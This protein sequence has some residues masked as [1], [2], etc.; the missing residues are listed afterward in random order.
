MNKIA[1]RTTGLAIK[2]ISSLSKARIYIHGKEN[3]C[4]GSLIFVA[5]HFTR[6]ETLILPYYIFRL[7]GIPAWSLA[8]FTLFRGAFGE[9]LEAIGAISTKAP[10][11]DRLMV[12]TLLTGEGSWIIYPEGRMVK[13]KKIFEKGKYMISYAGGKHPPHT[14]A[15]T[16]ALR[17]EFYRQRLNILSKKKIVET[18]RLLRLFQIDSIDAISNQNIYIIPVNVTYYPLRAKENIL[19]EMIHHLKVD[20]SDRMLE[21][22]MT[23]GSMLFS[24]VDVDI[25][26]GK[27]IGIEAYMSART[28]QRDILSKRE[29]GFDDPIPS[30]K[31]MRRISLAIMHRYMSSIYSMTTVNHDHLQASL[32]RMSPFRKLHTQDLRQ[33]L[34]YVSKQG[35]KSMRIYLHRDLDRNQLPLLTDNQ[36]N[37]FND[38]LSFAV[39]KKVIRVKGTRIEK[40]RSKFS[41]A[42]D[43]QRIRIDNPIEVMANEIE[44]LSALQRYLRRI[45]W[46]PGFW[47]RKKLAAQLIQETLAE[48]EQDYKTFFIEG[49]SKGRDI[50]RPLLYN[51]GRKDIGVVLIHGYLSAP[52]EVKSLAEYLAG[53]GYCVHAP[54]LKGHGT[55]PEDLAIRSYADWIE[56]VDYSYAIIRCLRK[57]VV[58]GGFSTGAGLAL[59]LAARV[60]DVEGVFAISPPLKLHDISSKLV[61][62]MDVWNKIMKKVHFDGAR[63]EFVE[64]DPENSYINYLRNPISGI[65]ELERF[66]ESVESRLPGLKAPALIVHSRNDPVVDHVGS[67]KAFELMGSQDK[68][69]LLFNFKRHGIIMGEGA[70]RVHRAIGD[71]L[72]D[73]I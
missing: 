24:G 41:S 35:L 67:K 43:F 20:I 29:I 69:Y 48:F 56:S 40:N 28:I 71:F 59:D 17:T 22:I 68:E 2:A 18:R 27:P 12:K 25:R 49:E 53:R 8:D 10:D 58:V 15:A 38:F 73:L 51:K 42:F 50:G 1:Y 32:L 61:P 33:K 34:F 16:L 3:I 23:E 37:K 6:I 5:N 21:E 45:A 30:R 70:V 52:L 14:G 26:F 46:T 36:L 47:I 65:R 19:S 60:P 66:M 57:R 39:D 7:T 72:D 13:N 9:I 31:M 55:S 11:R 64:N 54:R 62:A 44:P 4:R 63:K